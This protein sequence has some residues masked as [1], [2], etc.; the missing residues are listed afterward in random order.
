MYLCF[1]CGGL[2]SCMVVNVFGCECRLYGLGVCMFGGLCVGQSYVRFAC[3]LG[4]VECC[5]W[6]VVLCVIGLWL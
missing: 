5:V 2:V 4:S 6:D 1:G 3:L